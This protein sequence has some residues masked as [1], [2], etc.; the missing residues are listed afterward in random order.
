MWDTAIDVRLAYDVVCKGA[1]DLP[2]GDQPYPWAYN[3]GD[4]PP[5]L[6]DLL[7]EAQ[8]L[9]TLLPLNQCTGV[10]LPDVL[11]NGAM[12]R[13]LAQLMNLAHITS[14]QFF[15]INAGYATSMV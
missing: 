2:T 9:Q 15:V 1:G 14:E 5:N 7:D 6:S 3:L 13:R 8:L 11:R 10:N 12:D 4:I